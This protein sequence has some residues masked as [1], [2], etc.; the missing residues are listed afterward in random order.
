VKV[1]HVHSADF[2]DIILGLLTVKDGPKKKAD[3]IGG[4]ALGDHGVPFLGPS[5]VAA[6]F[7]ERLMAYEANYLLGH[8][9][10][11][12]GDGKEIVVLD[13]LNG[14]ERGYAPFFAFRKTK[15]PRGF[16][17]S[18][19][20]AIWYEWEMA[21]VFSCGT[22]KHYDT[23]FCAFTKDA[24]AVRVGKIGQYAR[25]GVASWFLCGLCSAFE[26][27]S[28]KDSCVVEL[29]DS[30]SVRFSVPFGDH[31]DILSERDGFLHSNGR[32]RAL[33]HRVLS[34]SR[35]TGADSISKV[36]THIRG[37]KVAVVDGIRVS[38]TPNPI[39]A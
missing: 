19:A 30:V 21:R 26:D 14:S 28:R 10:D 22:V 16:W 38:I 36:R 39:T 18:R 31:L 23:M 4:K 32:R 29:R 15:K 17:S 35:R 11:I 7:P 1:E 20:D 25:E 24:K 9:V 27:M 37:S 5:S 8:F 34:H 2:S 33:V 12:I 13:G 6:V 3:W